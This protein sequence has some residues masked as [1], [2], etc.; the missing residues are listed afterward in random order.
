M[1][2]VLLFLSLFL[3]SVDVIMKVK[4]ELWNSNPDNKVLEI[5]SGD[6]CLPHEWHG[7]VCNS[8]NNSLVI[9]EL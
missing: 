8:S 4:D 6:P 2:I 5:W 3:S 7:L 9:T 1:S